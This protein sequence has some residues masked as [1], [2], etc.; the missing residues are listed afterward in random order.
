M[1]V[2]ATTG[3]FEISSSSEELY[4]AVLHKKRKPSERQLVEHYT[5]FYEIWL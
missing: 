4:E 1:I 5:I 2:K 3:N